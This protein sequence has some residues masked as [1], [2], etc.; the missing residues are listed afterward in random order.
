MNNFLSYVI[1]CCPNKLFLAES[2]HHTVLGRNIFMDKLPS[3]HKKKKSKWKNGTCIALYDIDF[4][5]LR[6]DF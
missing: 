4:L 1:F 2:T 3:I 5:M 6:H